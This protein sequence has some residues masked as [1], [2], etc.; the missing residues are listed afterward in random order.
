MQVKNSIKSWNKKMNQHSSFFLL[1]SFFQD[2]RRTRGRDRKREKAGNFKSL[3]T[4]EI[5]VN[6]GMIPLK[7]KKQTKKNGY[8]DKKDQNWETTEIEDAISATPILEEKINHLISFFFFR[9]F[10]CFVFIVLYFFFG[11]F[12]SF[13]SFFFDSVNFFF[14]FNF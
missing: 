12:F 13:Y 1:Q 14:R 9:Y 7:T 10:V 2:N 3:A 6:D 8:A 4:H 11:S 5:P